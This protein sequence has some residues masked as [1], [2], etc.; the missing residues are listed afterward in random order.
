MHFQFVTKGYGIS[1]IEPG[2]LAQTSNLIFGKLAQGLV[3]RRRWFIIEL[4]S[5]SLPNYAIT[6]YSH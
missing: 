1:I 5:G 2:G 3:F 6:E 4:H